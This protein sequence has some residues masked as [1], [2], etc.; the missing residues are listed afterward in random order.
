MRKLTTEEFVDRAVAVHG[1]MYDYSKV[2]Y[3]TMHEDVEIV[4]E[5]HGSFF[6]SPSN[7]LKGHG[8]LICTK[9]ENRKMPV[10]VFYESFDEN[11]ILKQF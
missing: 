2:E 5:K 3:K 6:Q 1:D 10:D 4:C 11:P 9:I 8:C 7:H